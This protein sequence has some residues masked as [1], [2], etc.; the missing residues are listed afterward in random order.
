MRTEE[1]RKIYIQSQLQYDREHTKR[2]SCKLNLKT[3]ADIIAWLDRFP[4]RQG[5]IKQRFSQ[6][7]TTYALFYSGLARYS[8]DNLIASLPGNRLVFMRYR[9]LF[10]ALENIF[11]CLSSCQQSVNFLSRRRIN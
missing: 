9:I 4:N 6:G 2:F 8:I 11:I 3:D 7:V 5:Y 10:S 1:G